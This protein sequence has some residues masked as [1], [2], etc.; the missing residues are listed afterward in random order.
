MAPHLEHLRRSWPFFAPKAREGPAPQAGQA[1]ESKAIDAV[2]SGRSAQV[3]LLDS[4]G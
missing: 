1:P 2:Y 3:R 4:P